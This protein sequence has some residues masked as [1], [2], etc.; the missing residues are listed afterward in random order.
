MEIPKET[1][2]SIYDEFGKLI[3]GFLRELND[4]ALYIVFEQIINE[5]NRRKEKEQKENG[6]I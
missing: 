1:L 3:G 4:T 2:K 6:K 5:M